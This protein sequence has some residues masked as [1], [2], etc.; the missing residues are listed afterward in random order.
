MTG[1]KIGVCP[2]SLT[3]LSARTPG[4]ALH[5][6]RNSSL[7]GVE[8]YAAPTVP[9]HDEPI[10][11]E[12]PSPLVG[13]HRGQRQIA[14]DR[15]PRVERGGREAG[16]GVGPIVGC[17]GGELGDRRHRADGDDPGQVQLGGIGLGDLS[18]EQRGLAALRVS[19]DH[20][21]VGRRPALRV[22]CGPGRVEHPLGLALPDQVGVDAGRPEALVVGGHHDHPRLEQGPEVGDRT[23]RTE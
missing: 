1:A 15:R 8:S 2:G 7:V 6:E 20:H 22:A 18:G 3:S 16:V 10:T 9:A 23:E 12:S 13:E 11:D 4:L 14:V 5:P 19:D 21:R 17:G